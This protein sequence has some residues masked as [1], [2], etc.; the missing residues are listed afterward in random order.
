MLWHC[1]AIHIST[2]EHFVSSNKRLVGGVRIGNELRWLSRLRPLASF[3]PGQ[4]RTPGGGGLKPVP[5]ERTEEPTLTRISANLLSLAYND[6]HD[7]EV[8]ED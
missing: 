1:S 3:S 2:F 4:R 8:F 7:R 5:P 6:Q